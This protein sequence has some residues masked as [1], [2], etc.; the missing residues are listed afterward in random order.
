[1]DFFGFNNF[2]YKLFLLNYMIKINAHK[3]EHQPKNKHLFA[4]VITLEK[5]KINKSC[6]LFPKQSNIEGY[7]KKN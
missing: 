3:I 7:N 6:S 4:I 2:Y 5:T 1:M